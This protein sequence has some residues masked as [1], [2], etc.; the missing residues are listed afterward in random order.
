MLLMAVTII[1]SS[2]L[3]AN[4]ANIVQIRP[5]IAPCLTNVNPTFSTTFQYL[6]LP[7]KQKR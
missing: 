1:D 2:F 4:Y 3:L 5:L 6:L 7:D